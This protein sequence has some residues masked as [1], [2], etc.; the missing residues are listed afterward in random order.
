MPFRLQAA[1]ITL[2]RAAREHGL[3]VA[4]LICEKVVLLGSTVI[5]SFWVVRTLGPQLYGQFT[6]ALSI[7]TVL[8]SVATLG[9]ETIVLRRLAAMPAETA[10]TL[11]GALCL[12][13]VGSVTHAL[14]CWGLAWLM[15][16]AQ[17]SVAV[18]ALILASAAVFRAPEVVGLW[19]Q[20]EG[21]Y[22]DAMLVR[23]ISRLASDL[24]RVALIL[25]HLSLYAF[26][27]AFVAEAAFSG[28]AFAWLGRR[29]LKEAP[30]LPQIPFEPMLRQAMPLTTSGVIGALYARVDQVILY[31]LA[32]AL[33]T[34]YYGAAVRLSELF[35]ILATSIGTVAA[36]HFARLASADAPT[37]ERHL[38]RYLR[39]MMAAGGILSL[40]MSAAA[41]P[42]VA[43]IYGKAF[44]P[45]APIL[46][47]HAWTIFFIFA[48]VGLEPW[49]FHHQM[50][51]HFVPKAVL[52]LA[53]AVPVV[54]ASTLEWGAR[55][56]AAGV[57]LAYFVSV[58]GSNI[59]LPALRP[60]WRL[61]RRVLLPPGEAR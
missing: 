31:P 19:L 47:L 44:A 60:L 22:R 33:A 18:L 38:I 9:L 48:S 10:G 11:K 55:G 53:F 59:L 13:V 4:W 16:I 17:P 32:G 30:P 26:A 28:L 40:L 6:I 8:S 56:T 3:K 21:R 2:L 57:V 45:S 36:S 14:L 12:R 58:F 50:V 54:W 61:Q 5:I 41:A 1:A 24:L 34:G 46:S 29:F 37:F 39:W 25:M 52:T 42:I 27:W 7:V 51:R 35:T 43:L 20:N 15:N 23:V 49:F